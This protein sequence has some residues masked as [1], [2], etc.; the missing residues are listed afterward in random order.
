MREALNN[1]EVHTILDDYSSQFGT[2]VSDEILP[3]IAE[4]REKL[5]RPEDWIM[6]ED[7]SCVPTVGVWL[8]I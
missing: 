2:R 3:P 6:V 5:S 7:S 8:G 1:G 4:W